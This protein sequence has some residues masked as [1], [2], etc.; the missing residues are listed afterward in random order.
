MRMRVMI[1]AVVRLI[2]AG[3]VLAVRSWS[4]P[5]MPAP[6]AAQHESANLDPVSVTVVH[7][8]RSDLI[9]RVLAS[10]SVISIRDAKIGS[11]ISGRVATV[12]VD[13]GTR[14]AAGT[15]LLQLDTSDLAAQ[16]AQAQATVATAQAQLH[17]VLAGA[18]PQER[19]QSTDAVNQAKASLASAEASLALARANFARMQSLQAEGAVSRQDLDTAQTQAQV[20][21]AQVGQAQAALA[22]CEPGELGR[23]QAKPRAELNRCGQRG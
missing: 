7:A 19:L 1:M 14:V 18:R 15:P 6:G 10:G 13:E 11:K 9:S 21:Q 23:F 20:A 8:R 22:V 17:K 4:R 12:F 3:G 16:Q 2:L 5:V